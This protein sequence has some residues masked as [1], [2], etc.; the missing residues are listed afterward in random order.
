MFQGPL[1]GRYSHPPAT[2]IQGRRRVSVG[3]RELC[4]N[5][6][7]EQGCKRQNC[8]FLHSCLV[9]RDPHASIRYPHK[10]IVRPG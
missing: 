5:F 10:S 7:S 6:N 2:A 1:V 9:C 3:Q 8:K 4:N